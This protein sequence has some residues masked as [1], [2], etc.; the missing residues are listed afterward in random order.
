MKRL[1]L[2]ENFL[3]EKFKFSGGCSND[4]CGTLIPSL[5]KIGDLVSAYSTTQDLVKIQ[6]ELN[7][8]QKIVTD[9][10]RTE[11][12]NPKDEIDW[13]KAPKAPVF[14]L[15]LAQRYPQNE[16]KY[17]D[18]WYKAAERQPVFSYGGA[19]AIFKTYCKREELL[20]EDHDYGMEEISE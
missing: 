12:S 10:I 5:E 4:L 18:L 19:I 1:K 20:L 3:E 14:V 8:A 7:K 17:H 16:K 2:Y 11:T 9:K 6:G 13:D 15:T